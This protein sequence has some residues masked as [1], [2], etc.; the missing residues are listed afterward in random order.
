MLC[1]IKNSCP[2]Y[3][4]KGTDLPSNTCADVSDEMFGFNVNIIRAV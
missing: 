4:F 2:L 3:L 1:F